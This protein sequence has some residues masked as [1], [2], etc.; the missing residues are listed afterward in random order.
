MLCG[1]TSRADKTVE[2][3][4]AFGTQLQRPAD[5]AA[6]SPS[7][8]ATAAHSQ[9][10]WPK[11]ASPSSA[12]WVEPS[13]MAGCLVADLTES[14]W[15]NCNHPATIGRVVAISVHRATA[16]PD[17]NS[18]VPDCTRVTPINVWPPACVPVTPNPW[19][20][21]LGRPPLGLRSP[22]WATPRP[23]SV[24]PPVSLLAG[25]SCVWVTFRVPSDPSRVGCE[26]PRFLYRKVG[27][28]ERERAWR[29]T[30]SHQ[31]TYLRLMFRQ[32]DETVTCARRVSMGGAAVA[33]PQCAAG[34]ETRS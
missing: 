31:A 9:K 17:C 25:G 4:L 16:R 28:G 32:A 5:P 19:I 11:A 3:V 7:S 24:C 15:R 22:A 21:A 30:H 6:S 10:I 29:R 18:L 2:V 34:S 14:E 13:V 8:S 26:C 12:S 20:P 27:P 33:I 1:L 23:L